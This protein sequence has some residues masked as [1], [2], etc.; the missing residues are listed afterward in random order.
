V[1][2]ALTSAAGDVEH[3]GFQTPAPG[4]DASSPASR[5]S[6]SIALH[7]D[8]VAASA[9]SAAQHVERHAVA[10][11]DRQ[12]QR[13]D[14]VRH[15]AVGG[16]PV[17]A[18]DRPRRAGRQQ[19]PPRRPEHGRDAAAAARTRSAA[20]LA[21]RPRL[22]REHLHRLA[23]LRLRVDRR[24]RGPDPGRGEPPALQIVRN[25]EHSRK[26]VRAEL[27]RGARI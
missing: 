21:Q 1:I 11:G 19:A 18:G 16:H 8:G 4:F 17:A 9:S 20:R 24:Q 25:R 13:A 26:L 22:A 27:D 3:A 15:V 10:R 14:L 23:R 6:I 7:R 12:A 5:C 2:S